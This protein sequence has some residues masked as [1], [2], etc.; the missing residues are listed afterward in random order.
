MSVEV[1]LKPPKPTPEKVA[2]NLCAEKWAEEGEKIGWRELM[3]PRGLREAFGCCLA[4]WWSSAP[5][6]G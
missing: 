4:D 3:P 5:F 1:V 2:R 6:I